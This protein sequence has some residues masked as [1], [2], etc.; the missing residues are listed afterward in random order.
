L[1][2]YIE[3]LTVNSADG[4]GVRKSYHEF[5]SDDDGKT[6]ADALIDEFGSKEAAIE[7]M[8]YLTIVAAT[9]DDRTTLNALSCARKYWRK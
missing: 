5:D 2:Q 7:E 1:S 9:R 4:S 8:L 6:I 3:T